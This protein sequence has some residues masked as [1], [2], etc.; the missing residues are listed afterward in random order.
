MRLNG[1]EVL[2]TGASRG[3]GAAAARELAARGAHVTLSGRDADRLQALADETDAAWL[4]AD[5]N[6]PTGPWALAEAVGPVDVLVHCAGVGWAGPVVDMD[7]TDVERLV[8][9]DLVAP[10]KLARELLRGMLKRGHGHLAFVGSIAGLTGVPEEAVYSAAK[11]GLQAFVDALR[12]ELRET[13]IGV[14]ILCPGAVATEFWEQR[15]RPYDRSLPRLVEPERVARTLVR[16]IEHDRHRRV[17]PRWLAVA[18]AVRAV[19]PRAYDVLA[20]KFG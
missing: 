15:G 16:D 12:L 20:A 2:V 13:D 1:A 17:M 4:P 8:R 9:T 14:S 6:D 5:L 7:D 19:V 3:I 10:I 11:S 18:P